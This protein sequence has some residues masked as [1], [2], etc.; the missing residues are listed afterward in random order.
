[1]RQSHTSES[2]SSETVSAAAVLERALMPADDA[3]VVAVAVADDTLRRMLARALGDEGYAVEEVRPRPGM[4]HEIAC[5]RPRALVIEVGRRGEN[6][7]LLDALR[8]LPETSRMAVVTLNLMEQHRLAAQASGNVHTALNLPFDLI[9]L[10]D[11]L[12][13]ATARRPA[14]TR[15]LAQPLENEYA[16]RRAADVLAAAERRVMLKWL[17]VARATPP[18]ADRPDI[19]SEPFLDAL[20]RVLNMVVLALRHTVEPEALR[21]LEEF[22]ETRDRIEHH[23]RERLSLALSIDAC[24]REYHILG[25]ICRDTLRRDLPP[26]DVLDALPKLTALLDECVRISVSEYHRLALA[27]R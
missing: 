12:E 5:L 18:F 3:K 14:E 4:A 11:A 13:A 17:Q 25:D 22:S 15:L 9:D 26:L 1:V 23:A 24:V 2:Q 19:A 20:P 7:P 10:V 21:A 27:A 16:L 6:L 8:N